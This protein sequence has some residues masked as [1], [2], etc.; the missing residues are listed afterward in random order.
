[1]KLLKVG[2]PVFL[3]ERNES[4]GCWMQ[5]P[6]PS[7]EQEAEKYWLTIDNEREHGFLYE[8]PNRAAFR[9]NSDFTVHK[10]RYNF[11]GKSTIH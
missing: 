8:Y 10:L 3:L 9:K 1:M 7:S 2:K 4:F 6:Q 11:T 5:D